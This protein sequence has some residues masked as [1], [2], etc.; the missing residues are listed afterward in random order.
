[1]PKEEVHAQETDDRHGRHW[2][3]ALHSALAADFSIVR[4]GPTGTC[5][6]VETRPTDTKT[7][8]VGNKAFTTRA[9]AEKQITVL[10]K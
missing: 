1:V 9:E 8:I 10:C 2:R 3:G 7:V 4:E 5:Q 6:V